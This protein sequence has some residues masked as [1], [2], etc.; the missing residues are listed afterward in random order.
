MGRPLLTLQNPKTL[1][2]EA[3]GYRTAV[4]HLAPADLSGHDVCPLRTTGCTFACL[5]TAGRGRFEAVQAARVRRTLELFADRSGFLERLAHEVDLFIRA[6]ERA[7]L[8]PCVRLNGTS[9]LR[10][11]RWPVGGADSIMDLFSP[12]QFYD[13]TKLANR[14]DLPSNYHLTYSLAETAR[15]WTAHETALA[16]GMGVAVV[17][18]GAG[19]SRWPQ[20]FPETWNGRPLIDGDKSDLRFLDPPAVYVGLRAKGR[21]VSDA[22]GFVRDLEAPLV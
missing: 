11:E 12:V 18:R 22:S 3:A 10:F 1:K 5:N 20:P 17:L 7:G 13:Y 16:N 21:A 4:L 6:S 19:T 2:G 8:I 14:R 9:D 15:N